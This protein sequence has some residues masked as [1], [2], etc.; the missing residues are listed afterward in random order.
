MKKTIYLILLLI[1]ILAN[2]QTIVTPPNGTIQVLANQN[3]ANAK[4]I[5][6]ANLFNAS[7]EQYT[8]AQINSFLTPK[9][10]RVVYDT[11]TKKLVV[12]DG[13]IW[14]SAGGLSYIN[15]VSLPLSV[16]SQNLSIATAN[17]TTNGIISLSD[18][19]TFNNKQ[20][21]IVAGTTSQFWQGDKT[22]QPKATITY[23][24]YT[25]IVTNV[26]YNTTTTTA[27]GDILTGTYRGATIYRFISNIN[28]ADGYPIED[29]FY[30]DFNL[31]TK[32]TQRNL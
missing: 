28:N 32:I 18:W 25:D 11:T 15:S 17:A 14:Q 3:F 6:N 29:A 7:F 23:N 27:S 26:F 8:T 13:T 21:L 30:S 20:P 31:T 1:S 9:L 24:T 12:F 10:G 5:Y 19:T 2:S 22:W 16:N 4:G